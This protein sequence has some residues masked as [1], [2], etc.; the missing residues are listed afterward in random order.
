M[1]ATDA[2]QIKSARDV[3]TYITYYKCLRYVYQKVL[4][5]ATKVY[6]QKLFV[7]AQ[8]LKTKPIATWRLDQDR[9]NVGHWRRQGFLQSVMADSFMLPVA[10][11]SPGLAV[12]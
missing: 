1:T 2:F 6:D 10:K 5:F 8:C 7:Q 4:F 9:F 12:R 3:Q 11:L